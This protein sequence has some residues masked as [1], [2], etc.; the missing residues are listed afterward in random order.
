LEQSEEGS[1]E[2]DLYRSA[3]VKEFEIILEQAGKLLKK[4]LKPFFSSS[5]EVDK[6]Y[7]K[8]V[9]RKAAQHGLIT[10]EEAERWFQYR[11]NRNATSHEYGKG[12]ADEALEAMPQF[13]DDAK[14]LA[15]NIKQD[16]DTQ[17]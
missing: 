8:D 7:F 9:F 3:V 12:L 14:N 2:R 16:D 13:V 4:S 11:D 1:I 6:L 17:G 5:R 10:L 15:L